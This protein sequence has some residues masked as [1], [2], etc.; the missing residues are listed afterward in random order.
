MMR[1]KTAH[2]VMLCV[3]IVFVDDVAMQILTLSS[4]VTSG[5]VTGAIVEV[6]GGCEGRFLNTLEEIKDAERAREAK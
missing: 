5:H 1:L 2:V 3:L 6:A 4:P